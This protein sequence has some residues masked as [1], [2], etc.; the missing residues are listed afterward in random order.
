MCFLLNCRQSDK[1]N[2]FLSEDRLQQLR[3][4]VKYLTGNLTF[5]AKHECVLPA[6]TKQEEMHYN[7]KRLHIAGVGDKD[8]NRIQNIERDF[9]NS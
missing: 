8:Q 4:S 1:C 5:N 3:N 2:R 7:K 6:V 9:T